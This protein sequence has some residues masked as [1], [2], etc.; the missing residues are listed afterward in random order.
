MIHVQREIDRLAADLADRGQ[1][2][3]AFTL[4]ERAARYGELTPPLPPRLAGYLE[5]HRMRLFDHQ[6]EAVRRI[7]AGEEVALITP[8]ASGKTLAY[9][10]PV[11]ERLLADPQATALY[12]YPLK[13]LANDQL[14]K[15]RALEGGLA[16]PLRAHIYDGDTPTH[17]RPHIRAQARILLTNP[18]ALHHYLPWHG[19]W[20]PFLSGLSFVV[21]DEAHHYRGVFGSHVALLLRR[22][23]RVANRYGRDP[24]FVLCSATVA[25]PEEFGERLVGK[26]FSVIAAGG[27]PQGPR[28]FLFWDTN[29]DPTRPP[30][31]Q[32]ARLLA[33]LAGEGLQTLCFTPSRRMAEVVAGQAQAARPDRTILC[34][35]AGYLPQERRQIERGL[36]ERE[37]DGV[38]A[39]NAL[40]L[41]IDIG[42]LDAVII[43]G[44]PGTVNSVW[45][46][47]GRAGRGE[48]PSLVVMMGLADPLDRYFLARPRELLTRPHEHA[49][50]DPHNPEVSLRHLMCA[51]AE[52]P[53]RADE[54]PLLAAPPESVRQLEAA[55][56][57]QRAPV[58]WIYRGRMAP[59]KVVDLNR[60]SERTVRVECDGL[61]LETMDYERALR[62]VH[63]GAVTLHRGETYVVR[64]LDLAAGR[65][66]C[67]REDVDHYTDPLV[68]EE[69][70]ILSEA[71]VHRAGPLGVA[72]GRVRV[73]ERVVG[74]RVR[75][76]GRTIQQESLDLPA[77]E[78]DTEAVWLTLPVGS[79]AEPD[80][81]GLDWAGALHGVEHALVAM[82]PLLA[83]CDR[84]DLGGVSAP[85]HPDLGGPAVI[86]HEAFPSGVGIAAK[87]FAVCAAWTE[88]A[89]DLVADCGCEAGCPSCV[90]SPRC[91]N[92]NRPM[93]KPGAARILAWV[94]AALAGGAGEG[95]GTSA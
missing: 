95:G 74:Y 22:L 45:Q 81:Q 82:A 31:Q 7:R 54:L 77:V 28:T 89:R 11:V 26:P 44:Y 53:L 27:A 59:V 72:R 3:A 94:A 9:N 64:E 21:V 84:W 18:Y 69:V 41:G 78:F 8:T 63:P 58:G 85:F 34:Y 24:Q 33:F 38:A 80:G 51:A 14:E 35:R 62:E 20:R 66:V 39:T 65:A 12:L 40:E 19:K 15:L 67:V 16:L 88:A 4:P 86:V 73:A 30:T 5:H 37:V 57:V 48:R 1:V 68:Q 32:A 42:G 92:Q 25:N 50:I 49:I 10:L 83:M 13:A 61:L 90:L 29:R 71:R 46:Q 2:V 36:R 60:L 76:Q 56:L 47:A 91:G 6:A 70:R 55:R 43:V 17:F 23:R 93:D 52:F 75:S 79:G 87:L